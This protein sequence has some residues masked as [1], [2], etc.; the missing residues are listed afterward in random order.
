MPSGKPP[1][2]ISVAVVVSLLCAF[3]ILATGAAIGGSYL[4]NIQTIHREEAAAAELHAR[5]AQAQ[6]RNS[7]PM[8]KALVKMDDASQPPVVNA[9]G[10]PHSYGHKLATAIHELV[11][12]SKCNILLADV[13]KHEPYTEILRQLGG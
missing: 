10:S 8:C 12:S 1:S 11:A 2:P 5:E 6:I 13:A 9:S 7:V 4:L 3:F